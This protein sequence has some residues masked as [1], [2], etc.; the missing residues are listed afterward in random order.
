[1]AKVMKNMAKKNYHH[2]DLKSALIEAG[3]EIL[4]SDGLESLSMRA[5]AARVG[6]SHTAPKNHFDDYDGLLAAIAAEGF[7]RHAAEMRKGV[8]GMAKGRERLDAAA[9]GYVRFARDNPSL[10]RL[11]FS[12]RLNEKAPEELRNA[13]SRSYQVL[14]EISDG[15]DWPRTEI[16]GCTE[17]EPMRTE[18][19]LWAFVHGY[20]S[21][22]NEGRLP[23]LQNGE[24]IFDVLDIMPRFEY[25]K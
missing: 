15:L 24:P 11:M 2:G 10:F 5:I 23:R 14:E 1:M 17:F 22:I 18:Q 19:M 21:L 12:P 20:A 4:E 16:S 6:V 9:L 25:L 7:K 3:L 8:E 13:A